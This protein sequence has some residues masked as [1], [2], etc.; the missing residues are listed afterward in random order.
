MRRRPA[1]LLSCA[2]TLVMALN[3]GL[4]AAYAASDQD[5]V[6]VASVA[7]ETPMLEDD[8]LDG[9]DA[10]ADETA[11]VGEHEDEEVADSEEGIDQEDGESEAQAGEEPLPQADEQEAPYAAEDVTPAAEGES[12]ATPEQER[13]LSATATDEGDETID[14]S[15]TYALGGVIVVYNKEARD[16][17]GWYMYSITPQLYTGKA[18]TPALK[19]GIQDE[20]GLDYRYAVLEEGVD[21]TLSFSNNVEVGTATV[22]VTGRGAYSG[23]ARATFKI[24]YDFSKAKVSKVGAKTYTGKAIK[25]NPTVKLSG[26]KLKKGT[27]YKLSYKANRAVGKATII[28]KGKG[29]CKGSKKVT[30]TIRRA[31]IKKAKIGTVKAQTRTGKAIEPKPVVKLSG[32]KLKLG[33]D[34]TVS[35]KNNVAAGKATIV[36]AGMGNYSGTKTKT[37]TIKAPASQGGSSSSSASQSGTVYLTKTGECYHRDGCSSLRRSKIAIS[38]SDAIS[39]GYR[40]CKNCN[41]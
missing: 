27:D 16:E 3:L 19:V 40:P 22:T 11:T 6:E 26:V 28:I 38:R 34:Y 4:P 5:A 20:E 14:L 36:F 12:V 21:Y 35:Y 30:F 32:V 7:F 25:P 33:R 24:R 9:E 41:P 10:V 37:F 18:I 15:D 39:R 31:N 2:L 17:D 13:V 1:S 8:E 23:T 29:S